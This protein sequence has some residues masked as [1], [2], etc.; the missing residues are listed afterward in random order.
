MVAHACNTSYLG[1]RDQEDLWFEASQNNRETLFQ[2]YPTQRGAGGVAQ[3]VECLPN[4]YKVLSL[5]PSAAKKKKKKK[6]KEKTY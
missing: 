4:K 6:H 1:D 3:V 2:K 5:N